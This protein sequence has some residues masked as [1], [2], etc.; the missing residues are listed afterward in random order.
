LDFG[1]FLCAASDT[2]VLPSASFCCT[3]DG[4]GSKIQVPQLAAGGLPRR[5]FC[6]AMHADLQ[7]A[8]HQACAAA[9]LH[10]GQR[11]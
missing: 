6:R 8:A 11:D 10:A 5:V 1:M 9:G 2:A 3:F 4:S 7:A